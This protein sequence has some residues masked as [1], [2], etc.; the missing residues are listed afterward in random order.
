[1]AA[2][3]ADTGWEPGSVYRLLRWLIG[4]AGSTL[5]IHI[6][7]GMRPNGTPAHIRE[8]SEAIVRGDTSRLAN[9]PLFVKESIE[10]TAYPDPEPFAGRVDVMC[11]FYIRPSRSADCKRCLQRALE[12]PERKF[13]GQKRRWPTGTERTTFRRAV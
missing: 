3:F 8:D 1:M 9:P 7:R 11:T 5:P 2:V 10:Y 4:Q 13:N 6:V 12:D